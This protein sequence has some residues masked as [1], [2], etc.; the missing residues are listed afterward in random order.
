MRIVEVTG[1]GFRFS[2]FQNEKGLREG[3]CESDKMCSKRIE[4][5]TVERP[6]YK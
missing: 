4:K 1:R 5:I 2:I 3:H 6:E